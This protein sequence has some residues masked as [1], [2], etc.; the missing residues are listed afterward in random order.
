MKDLLVI[1]GASSI[2]KLMPTYLDQLRMADIPIHVEPLPPYF[3]PNLGV[4]GFTISSMRKLLVQHPAEKIVITDAF[5]VLFYGT[6]EEVIAK[7]PEEGVIMAAERNCYPEPFLS[8]HIDGPT[9]WRYVNGGMWAG[10]PTSLLKWCD[11]IEDD[12]TYDPNVLG[13]LWFNRRLAAGTDLV[14]LD[15]RT[16]LFYCMFLEDQGNEMQIVNGRP[17]NTLCGTHPP[18]LHF[19]GSWPSEPFRRMMGVEC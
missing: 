4:L 6:K 8:I 1:T 15:Y 3:N 17:T 16:E 10:T 7:V 14:N 2:Q 19:N 11:S 12:L 13:Q 5:D 18:F 9:P